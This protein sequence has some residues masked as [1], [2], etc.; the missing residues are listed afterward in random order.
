MT[1]SIK[2][3]ISIPEDEIHFKDGD[4]LLGKIINIGPTN[5][6]IMDALYPKFVPRWSN[7]EE[8]PVC[9][10]LGMPQWQETSTARMCACCK[11]VQEKVNTIESK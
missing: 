5:K 10:E 11:Y 4:K 9:H 8:C 7:A 2:S 3:D 6:E 1:I